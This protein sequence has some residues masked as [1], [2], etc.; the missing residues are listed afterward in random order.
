MKRA[1]VTELKNSLSA[2]LKEVAAGERLLVTDRQKPIAVISPIGGEWSDYRLSAM[3][4][5][6]LVAP[7]E[8]S[9]RVE[10]F[11]ACPKGHSGKPLTDA[12]L[13]ERETR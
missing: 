3:V 7:P 1:S 6:G 9:L 11:L 4:S 5:A 8:Q 10:A 13:E 12:A 2:L